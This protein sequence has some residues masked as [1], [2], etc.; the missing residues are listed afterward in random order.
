MTFRRF[1][2]LKSLYDYWK[3]GLIQFNNNGW[4]WTAQNIT[5]NESQTG[6]L[7]IQ[8]QPPLRLNN[9]SL[10]A[11]SE[12]SRM[13]A[14]SKPVN[15]FTYVVMALSALGGLISQRYGIPPSPFAFTFVAAPFFAFLQKKEGDFNHFS[16]FSKYLVGYLGVILSSYFNIIR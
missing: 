7:R 4:E 1:K 8:L 9:L 15:K 13:Y 12:N 14:S 2:S 16:S 5:L 11:N 10:L 3:E 6:V